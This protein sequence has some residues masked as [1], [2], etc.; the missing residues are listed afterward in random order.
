MGSGVTSDK[1]H[2]SHNHIVDGDSCLSQRMYADG[3]TILSDT[4]VSKEGNVGRSVLRAFGT[5]KEF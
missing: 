3:N 2:L 4:A 5:E 1:I